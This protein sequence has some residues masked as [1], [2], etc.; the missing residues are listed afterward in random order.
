[1]SGLSVS[2]RYLAIL[3]WSATAAQAADMTS[4]DQASGDHER[5]NVN[6]TFFQPFLSHTWPDTTNVGL[7]TESTCDRQGQRLTRPINLNAGHLLRLSGQ[8]IN[9]SSGIRYTA[10]A[11][12]G[13]RS[14]A[15]G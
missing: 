10:T 4:A 12:A 3:V 2:P 7:N 15:G 9:L 1:M 14:G 6:S 13:E 11:R 8:P 5:T